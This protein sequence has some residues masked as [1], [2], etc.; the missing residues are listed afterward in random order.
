[1]NAEYTFGTTFGPKAATDAIQQ[2]E[3]YVEAVAALL[4]T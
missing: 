2:A 1:M 3:A 4:S